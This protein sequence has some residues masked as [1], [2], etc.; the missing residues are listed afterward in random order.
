VRRRCSIVDIWTRAA[1]RRS[2]RC[3][4]SFHVAEAEDR[5][6]THG[7]CIGRLLRR[8]LFPPHAAANDGKPA[9]EQHLRRGRYALTP[10]FSHHSQGM[11][12]LP[13]SSHCQAHFDRLHLFQCST[14]EIYLGVDTLEELSENVESRNTVAFIKDTNFHHCTI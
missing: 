14:S 6:Q 3:S 12:N 10:R 8:L 4:A 2:F 5:F 9:S 11:S 1:R 13:F 7:R